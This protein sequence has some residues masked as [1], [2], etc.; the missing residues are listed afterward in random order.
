MTAPRQ[1]LGTLF[2]ALV[3]FVA[4]QDP[5]ESAGPER[6]SVRE[7]VRALVSPPTLALMDKPPS[8]LAWMDSTAIDELEVAVGEVLGNE[9]L[10][11]F[12]VKV[13]R[14]FGLGMMQPVIRA[15]FLLFGQSP[16]AVFSNLDR[17]FTLATRGLS[18]RWISSG[19]AQG[20]VEVRFD[21]PGTP[22][23]AYVV[24]QGSLRFVYEITGTVGESSDAGALVRYRVRW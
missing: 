11:E 5:V 8:S 1:G 4:Q 21:G 17:F 9:A 12:G 7:R 16:A 6:Q 13:S 14:L 10:L 20:V 15:A 24:L 19:D 2:R 22:H 3:E 18:F 23:A